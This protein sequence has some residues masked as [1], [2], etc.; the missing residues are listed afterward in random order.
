MLPGT[1]E[2]DVETLRTCLYPRD[3]EEVL[4]IR[5]RQC[6]DE[7]FVAWAWEKYGLFTVKSAYRLAHSMEYAKKMKRE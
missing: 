3:V 1:R 7:N 4:K 5:P 2:W 6:G